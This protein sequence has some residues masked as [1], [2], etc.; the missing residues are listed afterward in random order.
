[1]AIIDPAMLALSENSTQPSLAEVSELAWTAHF[2][3]LVGDS[4]EG[5]FVDRRSKTASRFATRSLGTPQAH[6]AQNSWSAFIQWCLLV[7]SW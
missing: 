2:G 5:T 6:A 7:C 3:G 1:V 4:G